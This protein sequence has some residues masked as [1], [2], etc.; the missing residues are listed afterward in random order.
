MDP[1]ATHPSLL[2]RVRDPSDSAAWREFDQRYRDLIL[3]YCRARGLQEAD[4]EDVRQVVMFNLSKTLRTFEYSPSRGRFRDYLGRTVRHSVAQWS[5]RPNRGDIALGSSML[6]GVCAEDEAGADAL[7][8]QEWVNHHYS[9]AMRTIRE[10]FE[11][12]SVEAFDR[13]LAGEGVEEVAASF[14][15]SVQAVHKIKQRIRDRLKQLIALQIRE[16]DEPDG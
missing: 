6:A 14:G 8:E 9:R 3:R 16:E 13:I 10:T 1:E 5:A 2:S 12:Q 11:P 4:A 7:W 15:S